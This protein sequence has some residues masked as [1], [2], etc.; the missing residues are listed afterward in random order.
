MSEVEQSA[1]SEGEV[2]PEETGDVV[3]EEE[4]TTST[5]ETAAEPEKPKARG[6]Q[7]RLDELTANWRGEQRRAQQLQDQNLELQRQLTKPEPVAPQPTEGEPKLENYESY[8]Q[9]VDARADYRADQK[10]AEWQSQQEQ[11][12]QE[13]QAEAQQREFMDRAETFRESH[14]DFDSVAFNPSLHVTPDMVGL[15]NASEKGPELLYH[16]GQ[17][18]NDAQR[19]AQLPP[20][21][22]AMELGRIEAG[23][24]ALQPKTDTDAPDAIEPLS[25]GRGQPGAKDPDDMTTAEWK[26]WREKQLT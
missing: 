2:L 7:K 25:G 18:P 22:A 8:E 3:E 20:G 13:T 6:V 10:I 12:S 21:Q 15:L 23:L 5:E 9:Y 19:I 24:G 4:S 11:R 26:V 17:N 1:D 14:E 16:L